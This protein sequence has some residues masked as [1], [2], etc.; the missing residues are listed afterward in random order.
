MAFNVNTIRSQLQVGGDLARQNLF[1]V[2]LNN[3][4]DSSGDARLRFVAQ[5]AQLPSS[6]LGIIE[7]PYFGRRIKLAGDRVFA[8]WQITIINDEDF[9]IRNA[10]EQWSNQINALERNV[11]DLANY[12]TDG[13]V[14]QF[15]KNGDAIREYK[16]TGIFPTEVSAIELDWGATDT[17]ETFTVTFQYDWWTVSGR[18]GTIRG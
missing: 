14:T 1:E 13:N 10:M 2:T 5:S 9:R 18:T 16:F 3:P 7:V 11:R 8:P 12:K 6:D 15:A 17:Y 4:A